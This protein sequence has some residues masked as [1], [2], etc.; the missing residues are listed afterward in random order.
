MDKLDPKTDGRSPDLVAEN[1]DH[2]RQLFPDVF[3]EGRV[4]F[5]ALRT[6]LGDAVDDAPERYG[7][8]WHGKRRARQIALQPSAGTL[9]P[10][11]DQSVNWDTTQNIFIE[12]DNLEVLK[13]LQ[14]SYHRKVKMIYI[15]PPY[16]TGKEFIYPDKWQDNLDTYLRYTGQVDGEGL[17]I[18]VNAETGGRYHTHWLNM[19][20]PRL[21]LARNLL[22]EDG[23]IFVSIDDHEVQNLRQLMDEVFG[24][25]NFVATFV[26]EKRTNRENRKSVSSRHDYIM[27]YCRDVFVLDS[28]IAQLPMSEEALARY[29]NPDQD[30]RGPWKSDPATAQ[31][32]HGTD[33]QF[34][35]FVAP[36]GR[37]HQLSSGRCWLYTKPVME[38]AAREGR[39]WF[40]KNGNGVPR[41]KT[42]LDAKERAL[43]PESIIF[44]KDA[45]TNE[46]AKLDLKRLFGGYA[47]FETPKPAELVGHLLQIGALDGLVLDFFAGAG[48]T[49]D[50][51]LRKN[52]ADGGKRRY[53]LVQLP[54]PTD[55][56]DYPTI[57]EITKA[58]LRKAGEAIA[59]EREG[60]LDLDGAG[61]PDLGFKVFKLDS[62]NIAP[63][64]PTFDDL[65]ADLWAAVDNIKQGRSE[66]D[67]L[68]E[69]LLKY[70]LDLAL[71]VETRT[72]AGKKV[73]VLGAGALVICLAKGVSLETV[74]GIAVLKDELKPEVMRVVFR[75]A[76]F[77][78]DVVK[79]NA[80]QILRR[81]G[82]EDVKAL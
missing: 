15:D 40:G 79:S 74:D 67:V 37:A 39:L 42:Y 27:C 41:I 25:E 80:L 47:V 13:L 11:P 55:H 77:E 2:L 54:E 28:A 71:P 51:V 36:N 62:S 68:Y 4:D 31:A 46:R 19:M 75:D 69:L 57:A 78:D 60:K 65:E 17:K 22:R 20:Y 53:I 61:D 23:V 34:Y 33:T 32:G 58:R 1:L 26:W 70:G 30:P 64:D 81:A 14:K 52:A 63:W 48:T 10:A 35:A 38:Q 45:S 5:E 18:S 21:K 56:D 16:N 43:T 72:L 12:G 73:S 66:D 9:R 82:I 7:L 44:A 8:S 24:G 3:T 6:I 29:K 76:S 50:A 59:K 49:G